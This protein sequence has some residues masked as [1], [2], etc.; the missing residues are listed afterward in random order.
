LSKLENSY[1]KDVVKGRKN[2]AKFKE[3]NNEKYKDKSTFFYAR[4][5]IKYSQAQVPDYST[6]N[7]NVSLNKSV[8]N[9]KSILSNNKTRVSVRTK[10]KKTK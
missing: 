5:K 4:A 1:A 6:R 10:S 3:T 2:W 7:V 8:N 9:S